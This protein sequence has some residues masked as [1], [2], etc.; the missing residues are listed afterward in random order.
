V[1]EHIFHYTSPAGLFSILQENSLR[2]TDCQFMNDVSEYIHIRKPFRIAMEALKDE[3]N[4]PYFSELAT[5]LFDHNRS[6]S[7]QTSKEDYNYYL[8]CTSIVPDSLGM[9]NHYIKDKNYQGYSIGLHVKCLLESFREIS[10]PGIKISHGKV[11]YKEEEQVDLL[12]DTL[13]EIDHEI[14]QIGKDMESIIRDDRSFSNSAEGILKSRLEE[15]RLFFKDESFSDEREYRLV[16]K[17]SK[18]AEKQFVKLLTRGYSIKNGIFIPY[19]DLVFSK[20][21]AIHSIKVAPMIEFQ[22]AKIGLQRFLKDHQYPEEKIEITQS[23]I[24]IRF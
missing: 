16:L 12:L 6:F 11:L 13:R 18:K 14:M 4:Y 15:F 20:D 8:F 19:I 7:D 24:P 21:N 10:D 1:P 3:L 22:L 2:F 9:W 23:M 5:S 17:I